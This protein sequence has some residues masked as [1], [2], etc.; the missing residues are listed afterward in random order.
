MRRNDRPFV[1]LEREQDRRHQ[2]AKRFTDASPGFD[3]EMSIFLQCAR[4]R[5]CHLL[6]LWTEF[7]VLCLREKTVLRKDTANSFDKFGA[8]RIFQRDHLE[9]AQPFKA[10]PS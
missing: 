5:P 4:D 8:E 2:V 1:L 3:D 10:G 7:E 9:I 6:L